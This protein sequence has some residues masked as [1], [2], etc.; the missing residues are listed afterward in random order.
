MAK[1]S[2]GIFFC[3]E[4]GYESSNGWLGQCPACKAWN[5]FV[6]APAEPASSKSG[7]GS[8]GSAAAAG[9]GNEFGG[10]AKLLMHAESTGRERFV[11]GIK[12]LDR[13]LGGGLV[14]GSIVLVSG[15]PGIGKSTLMLMLSGTLGKKLK[16]L[17]VS[18]EES[19]EQIKMRAD[20]L[21]VSAENLYVLAET[22]MGRI[23]EQMRAIEPDILVVDSIQTM[24]DENV[25]GTAG[26]VSQVREVT[27]ALM[28]ISKSKGITTL[29]VGHVTKDGSIAGPRI[30]EH[31][32]DTVLYFEGERQMFYRI[33]RCVKNRFGSTNE[34]GVF[35]MTG[36]GLKEVPNPS[37][38]FLEGRPEHVPGSAVACVL[39]G[40][41]P[42]L[43]EVQAL[44]SGTNPGNARRM[45]T[46]VDYNRLSMLLAVLE[47]RLGLNIVNC[48]AYVNVIG[49]IKIDE[50]AADLAIISAIISSVTNVPLPSD[51]VFFGEIGL[52]GEVRAVTHADRR[53][54]EILRLGFKKCYMPLAN[55]QAVAA[56]EKS[57]LAKEFPAEIRYIG[58]IRELKK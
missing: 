32:V 55:K 11:T 13:V 52:T 27:A 12:E 15:D 8:V 45:S 42:M 20:R 4:C 1:T 16:V 48:D 25:Q 19:D 10:E 36:T 56:I 35:E 58:N 22:N 23:Y 33:M 57:E 37:G 5:T 39:E 2:K 50:P 21:S 9:Y 34:I 29:V 28:K 46:G 31:M 17:Y 43:V 18:G 44:I 7:K 49:G 38:A 40:T 47:K 53:L 41:R 14:K 30:L 3:R 24:C 54:G 6:E 51:C 26:S